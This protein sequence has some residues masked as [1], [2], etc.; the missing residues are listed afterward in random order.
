[1]KICQIG[2]YINDLFKQLRY[3]PATVS[4]VPAATA[5]LVPATISYVSAATVGFVPATVGFIHAFRK[6]YPIR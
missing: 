4:Y 2:I 3:V 6:R 5:S 1:M